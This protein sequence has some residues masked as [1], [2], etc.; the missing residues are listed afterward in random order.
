MG[1]LDTIFTETTSVPDVYVGALTGAIK[2]LNFKDN[3]FVNL[4]DVTTLNPKEDEVVRMSFTDTNKKDFLFVTKSKKFNFYNS[5]H[6]S[7]STIFEKKSLNGNIVGVGVN[8]GSDILT[9]TSM[10]DILLLDNDGVNKLNEWNAESGLQCIATN[11][12]CDFSIFATGGKENNLKLWDL[13]NKTKIFE[14]KNVKHD[15]L[16][17]RV[18]IN[19]LSICFTKSDSKI[20]TSTKNHRIRMY[21][22]KT[23]QKPVIDITWLDSPITAISLGYEDHF[24]V[25]G[26]SIGEMGLFDM[27]VQRL[28]HKYKG[29]SGSI[30]SIIAHPSLPYVVSTGLDRFVRLHDMKKHVL[31]KKYYG[32]VRLSNLLMQDCLSFINVKKEV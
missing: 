30:R 2:G 32:K 31:I 23:Q 4:N 6:N 3:T 1:S 11:N 21:D 14:A 8:N 16:E 22:T 13:N 27:R 17:L 12:Y 25:V 15:H 24:V 28:V 10:G 29:A 18:P 9:V 20:L 26:N 7:I 19:I 5:I